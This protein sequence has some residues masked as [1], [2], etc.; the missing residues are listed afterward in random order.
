[1]SRAQYAVTGR[2]GYAFCGFD[3]G[4]FFCLFVLGFLGHACCM[5]GEKTHH[6]SDH[7]GSLTARPPGNSYVLSD[8]SVVISGLELRVLLAIFTIFL[9]PLDL[10]AFEISP[11]FGVGSLIIYLAISNVMLL[12]I[13]S[14]IIIPFSL[15][16]KKCPKLD[17]TCVIPCVLLQGIFEV[18]GLNS[19]LAEE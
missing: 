15:L 4:G 8:A 10:S 1:M 18:S 3:F 19:A 17:M 11:P 12:S 5:Q 9:I 7:T 13:I 16:K 6:S 14:L 2:G